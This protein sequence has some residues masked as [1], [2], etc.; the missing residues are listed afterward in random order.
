MFEIYNGRKSFYQWDTGQKLIL[1]QNACSEVHFCNGTEECS[2]VC[3]VHEENG[4]QL[5]D[6]PNI[7]LQTAK[8]IK[9]FAFVCLEGDRHT[10][11]TKVFQVFPR[12]KPS[13]YVYTETE[14][15]TWDS[16]N[17]RIKQIGKDKANKNGWNPNKYIGT[18]ENGS[19]VEKDTPTGGSGGT[20]GMVSFVAMYVNGRAELIDEP[21][22]FPDDANTLDLI[23]TG[24]TRMIV[25][26]PSYGDDDEEFAE[27]LGVLEFFNVDTTLQTLQFVGIIAGIDGNEAV[28]AELALE[29]GTVTIIPMVQNS[30]LSG[31]GVGVVTITAND[32]GTY[33]SSHTPAQIA[34]MAQT[35]AVV[36]VA[37]N[38]LG[39]NVHSI[40]PLY[41]YSDN[42]AVFKELDINEDIVD[43]KK[44][45]TNSI[46]VTESGVSVNQSIVGNMTGASANMSGNNGF[47]PAPQAGEQDHVLHGD[48]T[49]RKFEGGGSSVEI[50]ATL[51]QEGKAADAKTVGDKISEVSDAIA[52][53][54]D[55]SGG[56]LSGKIV[57]PTG[58]EKSGFT[59]SGDIK[60]IGYGG[61]N[62]RV[63]DTNFPVQ[64]RGSTERP[65]YNNDE[66]VLKTELDAAL[67]SYITD[68]DALIGGEN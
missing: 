34:A 50:D 15:K 51:K 4:V 46:L 26:T 41:M 38:A 3:E 27:K 58:D 9:A 62:F 25:L 45:L 8:P 56:T 16:L 17:E 6:V 2:L 49:W 10:K 21:G 30:A 60:I 7:L 36:A 37:T 52:N 66:L 65:K 44:L 35:G 57:L 47:V 12:S 18:D 19:L 29:T 33:R 23:A 39:F 48:G 11:I 28:I 54:L 20:V 1:E 53:K 40:I 13:T 59:N 22:V 43:T 5:V 55:K 67:S 63:G 61:G 32:D 68:I 24:Q 14:C 31:G 42:G 64:L